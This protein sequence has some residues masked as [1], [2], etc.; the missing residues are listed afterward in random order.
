MNS[1]ML[2]FRL[3]QELADKVKRLSEESG[4]PVS[5]VIRACITRALPYVEQRIKESRASGQ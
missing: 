5:E 4:L 1:P 2:K 3:P